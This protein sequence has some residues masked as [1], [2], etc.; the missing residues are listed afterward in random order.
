MLSYK[1]GQRIPNYLWLYYFCL[2]SIR[3]N[4]VIKTN[5]LYYPSNK[6]YHQNR[7][8]WDFEWNLQA[9]YMINLKLMVDESD[10]ISTH[11]Q[12]MYCLDKR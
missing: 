8:K 10:L 11:L 12:P 9:Q 2:I 3:K 5:K 1:I 7:N 6:W 4:E